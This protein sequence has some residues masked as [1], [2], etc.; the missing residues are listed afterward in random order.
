MFLFLAREER[1]AHKPR[2]LKSKS[3]RAWAGYF[4][5]LMPPPRGASGRSGG[6]RVSSSGVGRAARRG[7]RINAGPRNRREMGVRANKGKSL[8]ARSSRGRRLRAIFR[9][10]RKG[11]VRTILDTLIEDQF[12][13]VP[14]PI[15][16]YANASR[17]CEAGG[18]AARPGTILQN[19]V[20]LTFD[21]RRWPAKWCPWRD[22][23]SVMRMNIRS[24]CGKFTRLRFARPTAL[25]L[26]ISTRP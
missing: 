17:I 7:G 15:C 2:F 21:T 8:R 4:R 6:A 1:V 18:A 20:V 22:A 12:A 14:G 16:L 25:R 9:V 23:F 5:V 10:E 19:H 24:G 3:G 13:L 26:T 11:S